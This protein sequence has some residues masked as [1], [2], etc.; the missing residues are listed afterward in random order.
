MRKSI[1]VLLLTT[2]VLGGC[3]ALGGSR[4][5]PAN[6]FG[7]GRA[8]ETAAETNPLIPRSNGLMSSEDSSAYYGTPVDQ[9][10][11]LTVERVPGGAIIRIEALAARQGSFSVKVVPDSE[12]E[13]AVDGVLSYTLKALVAHRSAIGTAPSRRI[14]AAHHVTDQ[15]LE[16]VRQIRVS[17][18]RN[19]MTSRR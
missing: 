8:T 5:N 2:L 18:T 3:G 9:I 17:G 16:G 13:I 1:A 11:A 19:S 6:W 14:V 7:R 15:K 4:L 12:D 10:T